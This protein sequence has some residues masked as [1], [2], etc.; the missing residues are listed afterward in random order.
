MKTYRQTP[1]NATKPASRALRPPPDMT[2]QSIQA[3]A[4]RYLG[5]A[6]SPP[7][8]SVFRS[9]HKRDMVTELSAVFLGEDHSPATPRIPFFPDTHRVPVGKVVYSVPRSQKP[10]LRWKGPGRSPRRTPCRVTASRKE[11][12]FSVSP[13]PLPSTYL[14]RSI[15]N[16][17]ATEKATQPIRVLVVDDHAFFRRG[18]VSVLEEEDDITVVGE[19]GDGEEAVRLSTEFQP[20][21][22]L[23]DV[24]MPHFSGIEACPRIREVAP[25]TKFVML[26][27]SDEEADLFDALKAGATGYLLKEISVTELPRAVRTIADGL[28]FINPSMATKLIGEFAEL[29]KQESTPTRPAALPQLTPRETEVLKLLARSLNNRE[30]GERLFITENTVKNHVR[31]ILE[32][33]Q[34]HSR[35]EAAI[36]AVRA[37]YLD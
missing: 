26:T 22:V 21:V 13:H 6:S 19:A 8:F 14:P 4:P 16:P 9:L 18:L 25:H 35:T 31:S 20:D 33:L 2:T 28:S 37:E 17:P 32:K 23:M 30:I 11:G 3:M 29:A 34:V 27:M 15:G 5:F 1:L 12:I 10:V 7:R 36:Y 24:M